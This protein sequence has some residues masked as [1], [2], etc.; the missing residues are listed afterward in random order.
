M[1]YIVEYL[2]VI[3]EGR[4]HQH[5]SMTEKVVDGKISAAGYCKAHLSCTDR[6]K[7]ALRKCSWDKN[8]NV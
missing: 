6:A 4:T 1:Q 2:A 7:A 8:S 3:I 5:E